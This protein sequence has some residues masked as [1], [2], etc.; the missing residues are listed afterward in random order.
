LWSATP[1]FDKIDES[2]ASDAD[3]IV[4]ATNPVNDTCE[5]GLNAATDPVSS[6]N[7]VLSYRYKKSANAGRQIDLVVRLMQGS[8]IIVSFTHTAIGN[9]IV[10]ADQTL[11]GGQADSI[12]NYGDLRI[13][14]VA[15]NV[16]TGTGRAGQ[17]TWAEFRCPK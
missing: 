17:V 3:L 10:Q 16:G 13:R 2:T 11:T 12:T 9:T 8:T 15:N 6:V 1:L 5:V 7:H 14:F 4:S